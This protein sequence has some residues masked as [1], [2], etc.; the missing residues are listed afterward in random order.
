M[1]RSWCDFDFG[2]LSFGLGDSNSLVVGILLPAGRMLR[3]ED[4]WSH[5]VKSF[6]MAQV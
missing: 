3:W 6:R 5:H 2:D 1:F 4:R